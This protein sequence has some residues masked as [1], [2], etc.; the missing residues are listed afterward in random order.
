[1]ARVGKMSTSETV[2]RLRGGVSELPKKA[3]THLESS[4]FTTLRRSLTLRFTAPVLLK[5]T[6]APHPHQRLP[7]TFLNIK[8]HRARYGWKLRKKREQ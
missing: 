1:M 8:L 5:T 6:S 2:D 3:V 4:V 7:S